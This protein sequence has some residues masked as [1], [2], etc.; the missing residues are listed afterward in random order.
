MRKTLIASLLV[1]GLIG[2]TTAAV[3]RQSKP[4]KATIDAV[5]TPLAPTADCPIFLQSDQSGVATHVGEWSGTGTTCGFN[6]R[7]VDDPPFDPGGGPPYFVADFINDVT[8]TAP[9][10]DQLFVVT[11]GVRVES[12]PD[13]ASG[14]RGTTTIN[15]GTG[16]FLG[17]TGEAL[18]G[19]DADE[20]I[21]TIEGWIE[22][23]ASDRSG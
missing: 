15:G 22:Y 18:G 9:N 1:F 10:G 5:T 20:E 17:A 2:T 21:N 13:G 19:R 8:W 16:R 4:F 7:I 12:I 3:A 6:L 11:N 14:N 23:D